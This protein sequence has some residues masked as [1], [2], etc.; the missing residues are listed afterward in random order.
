MTVSSKKVVIHSRC[1]AKFKDC[2]VSYVCFSA[3]KLCIVMIRVNVWGVLSCC[4][5]SVF[6]HVFSSSSIA[7]CLA[8]FSLIEDNVRQ[9]SSS[10]KTV[11]DKQHSHFQDSWMCWLICN[12]CRFH[13]TL[14]FLPIALY[15]QGP[16]KN[17]PTAG[18]FWNVKKIYIKL[19]WLKIMYPKLGIL[20]Q[21]WPI[22][23]PFLLLFCSPIL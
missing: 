13:H 7:N 23:C 6:F 18:F 4:C 21:A 20:L 14:P 10:F 3:L 8:Y 12:N 15:H 1:Q 5:Y 11:W 19:D 2:F 17:P 22:P 9:A 16:Y